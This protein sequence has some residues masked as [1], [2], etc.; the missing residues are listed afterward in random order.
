[1]I[2][3]A[4]LQAS[5]R[6]RHGFMTRQGG[7]SGDVFSSL[8]CGYGSGDAETN[9]RANREH[10]ATA[11]GLNA[12]NLASLYQVHSADVVEVTDVWP[13]DQRPQADAMVTCKP[14]IGLGILTADCVPVLFADAEEKVIGAAHAGWKGALA[15][16]V[17]ATIAAMERLGAERRSIKAAVGPCIRQASYE[18]GPELRQA[19][20]DQDPGHARYFGA[21]E[22]VGH[23]MFDLAGYVCDAV[24]ASDAVVEDV[25]LDTYADEERFFSYRRATHRQE[26]DYGRGI[27]IISLEED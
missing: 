18:V 24:T 4:N 3:A 15:G 8:N 11:L 10:A 25:G 17:E 5:A 19:F 7:V 20:T 21:S 12:E 9:V 13:I 1:M 27:S 26:S 16:V 22:R 14:G 2:R 6:I 23:F